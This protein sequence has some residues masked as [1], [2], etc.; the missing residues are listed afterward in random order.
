MP[1]EDIFRAYNFVLDIQGLRSG[2]FTEVSGLNID[3]EV[4]PYREG[5]AA[6]AERKLPGRISYGPILCRWGMSQS[7]ELWDW[8]QSIARGEIERKDISIILLKPD[9]MQEEMRWNCYSAWPCKW[10]ASKLEAHRNDVAID[11]MTFVHERM[12]RA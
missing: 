6:P 9:G 8:L 1:D 10:N 3:I 5:G 12:E 7:T 2:Y 11:A 4:I